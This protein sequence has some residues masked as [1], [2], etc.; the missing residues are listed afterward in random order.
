MALANALV[1]ELTEEG[2]ST[3]RMLERVPLDKLDWAPHVK[4]MTLGRLAWHLASIPANALRLVNAGRFDVADARP[5]QAN[6][7]SAFVEAYQQN[8]AGVRAA[9]AAMDDEA[10]RAP[11][12]L[13]R[14]GTVINETRKNV[15]LRTILMNHSYHH[16]GQLSVYLRLLD[17]PVPAIYG[18]SAD[19][20]M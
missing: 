3:A 15:I 19:E 7:T 10:L 8:L 11:F 1:A 20:M 12:T 18:T 2:K 17:V 9:I 4:S 6:D 16:R 14:N 5:P 13:L